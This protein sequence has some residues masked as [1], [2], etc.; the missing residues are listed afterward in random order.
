VRER[1]GLSFKSMYELRKLILQIPQLAPFYRKL[2][3]VPG[4]RKPAEMFFRK[5][6]EVLRDLWSRPNL[7][8]KIAMVPERRFTDESKEVRLY[9]GFE[10]G[11]RSWDLQDQLPSGATQVPISLWA[12][13]TQLSQAIG[14]AV[15]MA[16]PVYMTI[17]S[18]APEVQCNP[19]EGAHVLVALLP[20]VKATRGL[21]KVQTKFFTQ[22]L[23]HDGLGEVFEGMKEAAANGMELTSANGEVRDAFPILAINS[24][25]FP[26]QSLHACTRGCPKC[27]VNQEELGDNKLG[28]PRDPSQTLARIRK[29]TQHKSPTSID[30]YLK[31]FG[32][33][34]VL[35]PYWKDWEHVDIHKAMAPDILHQLYQ[36]L[37]KHITRWCR[38]LLGDAEMDA[39]MAALPRAHGL[40]HFDQ[41]ISVLQSVSGTEHR[42]IA[43]QLEVVMASAGVHSRVKMALFS[44]IEFTF[45]VQ[46]KVHSDDTLDDIRKTLD[47]FHEH[48]EIFVKLGA[49][50][51]LHFPKM[52]ALLHYTDSIREIG[53]L[54]AVNTAIGERLH[55]T[56]VKNGYRTSNKKKGQF[57]A[58]LC[59][60]LNTHE[61]MNWLACRVASTTQKKSFDLRKRCGRADRN[62][63]EYAKQP[64]ARIAITQIRQAHEARRFSE[65]LQLFLEE[66]IVSQ[67]GARA[68]MI[69][70]IPETN[71]SLVFSVWYHMHFAIP[72]LQ[73]FAATDTQDIA[74]AHPVRRSGGS[75]D[76]TPS[77]F[78]PIFVRP[79]EE[80]GACGT[81]GKKKMPCLTPSLQTYSQ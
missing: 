18:I 24:L 50:S 73:T 42:A 20:I 80:A 71:D 4:M 65:L 46:A 37:I 39:R 51:N 70:P 13:K 69:P 19:S 62:A 57:G 59:R 52:H 9:S 11:N 63:I 43:R 56:Q 7:Q 66:F 28:E 1:L 68:I 44:L 22:R 76:S 15:N 25:D 41:G 60:Y 2:I 17:S 3:Y 8:G 64:P 14:M 40:R 38:T 55:I 33:N 54:H 16:Y 27:D 74:Y 67:L 53:A 23:F 30:A 32:L 75:S 36:G 31:T 79:G 49:C 5:P 81:D 61:A 34:F 77:R 29:A 10:T 48:K 47:R 72:D 35:K 12:D 6:E 26:E 21:G 45:M 78:S 58:Q